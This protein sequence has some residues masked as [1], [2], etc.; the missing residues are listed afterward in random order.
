MPINPENNFVTG[1]KKLILK[2]ET[3]QGWKF[4]TVFLNIKSIQ[5]LIKAWQGPMLTKSTAD[6]TFVS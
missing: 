6:Y 4:G 2:K 5:Y 1:P 3:I